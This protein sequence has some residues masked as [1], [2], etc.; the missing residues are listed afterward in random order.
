MGFAP[1]YKRHN[2]NTVPEKALEWAAANSKLA[3]FL[4]LVEII[5]SRHHRS[6]EAQFTRNTSMNSHVIL[7]NVGG[8]FVHHVEKT[9]LDADIVRSTL[10]TLTVYTTGAKALGD[11]TMGDIYLACGALMLDNSL[12]EGIIY[13]RDERGED[14]KHLVFISTAR[15]KVPAELVVLAKYY[16]RELWAPEK[17]SQIPEDAYHF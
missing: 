5:T 3:G 10:G 1:I 11:V 13:G 16:R 6:M 8:G 12:K 15:Y 14:E 7:V 17:V 9:I 2:T 4:P